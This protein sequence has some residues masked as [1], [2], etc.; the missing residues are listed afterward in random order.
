MPPPAAYYRL[1]LF[2]GTGHPSEVRFYVPGVGVATSFS[3][4]SGSV[5]SV[6]TN[7]ALR[8]FD[9][10]TRR[11]KPFPRPR[12]DVAIDG[13]VVD[14]AQSYERLLTLSSSLPV[15]LEEPDWQ[16]VEFDS[17]RANPWSLSRIRYSPGSRILSRNHD[18]IGVPPRLAGAIERSSL[19]TSSPRFDWPLV[20]GSL[21]FAF[22]LG[23][24]TMFLSRR[25]R[26]SRWER[27]GRPIGTPL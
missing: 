21:L 16:R 4:G 27:E 25:S 1:K 24:T 7:T 14:D 9:Q 12:F 6:P 26:P 11:L 18:W 22:A 2:F 20:T 5:W 8:L 3:D 23:L 10:V 17:A 19:E 15:R 13:E